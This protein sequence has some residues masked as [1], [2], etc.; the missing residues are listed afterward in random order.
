MKSKAPQQALPDALLQGGDAAGLEGISGG[1]GQ[2]QGPERRRDP[3]LEHAR[4][5]DR[6]S[7]YRN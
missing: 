2:C 4:E 1:S 5:K 6:R 7:E 3:L